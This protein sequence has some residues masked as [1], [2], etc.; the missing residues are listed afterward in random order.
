MRHLMCDIETL[1]TAS[2]GV[3][4]SL[5]L[6][7]FDPST[8]ATE[9]LLHTNMEPSYQIINGRTVSKDTVLWWLQQ[10]PNA[11]KNAFAP[12]VVMDPAHVA[13]QVKHAVRAHDHLWANDPDFDYAF[14]RDF[15]A[16]YD[17]GEFKW[18]FWKHRSVRTIRAFCPSDIDLG[19]ALAHDPLQDSL[20][21]IEDISYR[22]RRAGLVD[23]PMSASPVAVFDADTANTNEA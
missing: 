2:T 21:Q 14:L 5:A 9:T 23:A 8:G 4:L 15:I 18:P 7:A 22:M 10:S 19:N 20:F 16:P 11:R 6:V 1:D 3:I 17:D 12:D 13:A